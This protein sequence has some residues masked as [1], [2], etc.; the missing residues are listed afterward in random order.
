[1]SSALT[2]PSW[3]T[4]RNSTFSTIWLF[5]GAAQLLESLATDA[6]ELD[7]F[8][9]V[10]QR[11]RPFACQPHDRRIERAGQAALAGADQQQ[12]HLIA[13]RYLPAIRA[14]RANS[15]AAVAMLEIT[16]SIFSA[17]GRL[18][19]P[20]RSARGAAFDAATICM[21]FVIF[22]VAL[23]EA[24]RTRMSLS[25]AISQFTPAIRSVDPTASP[26][27]SSCPASCRASASCFHPRSKTWMRRNSLRQFRLIHL[28]QVG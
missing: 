1:M 18:R 3:R 16:A 19:L 28:A 5:E 2:K 24:M 4:E 10:H 12:M 8:A 7:L 15:A 26:S 9:L 27:I 14:R 13:C 23:V 17:Y 11:Q 6:E 21:A 25:E 22:C 20:R